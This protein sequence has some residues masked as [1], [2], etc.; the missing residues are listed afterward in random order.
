MGK[1]K[2]ISDY[3]TGGSTVVIVCD[4]NHPKVNHMFNS[5]I[6]NSETESSPQPR[7]T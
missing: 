5:R 3:T 2:N 7:I 6:K 1:Y 4:E